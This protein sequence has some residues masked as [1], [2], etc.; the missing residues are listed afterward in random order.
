MLAELAR[1]RLRA[2][3]GELEQALV[4]VF[5]PHHR[6]L[7]S[8]L[9]AQIDSLEEAIT[10][11]SNE[12]ATHMHAQEPAE[13]DQPEQEVPSAAPADQPKPR[14]PLTWALAIAL[15]CTIPGI[16]RRSAEGILA[17]IGLNMGRFPTA[18]HLASWAGMCP[19]NHES[20]GKRLSG[21][22]RKGNSWLRMLLVEAAHAAAHTKNTY[23]SA[24]Y[25]RL[26]V[27]RGKKKAVVAVGHTILIIIYHVLQEQQPYAELGGNYFDERER[28]QVERRLVRRLEKLG[29]EVALTP[30]PSAA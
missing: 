27:R 8:E 3:R 15:L 14:S 11:V 29:Y 28:Q 19:G 13:H 12:I 6:F 21:R 17:E 26:A 18:A 2:K 10:R 25:H 5:K 7:L 30:A 23:L 9:L 22:M 24:Q 16:G 4:G 20:A 1:G